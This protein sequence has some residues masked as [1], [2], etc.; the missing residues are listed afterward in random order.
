MTIPTLPKVYALH[1]RPASTR[2]SSSLVRRRRL[3]DALLGAAGV[4]LLVAAVSA[5]LLPA[6]A[7]LP[8][9]ALGLRLSTRR[10]IQ[11]YVD[12]GRVEWL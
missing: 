1:E 9:A 12:L 5:S 11:R 7:A 10:V 6:L 3:S 4:L 8:L 2:P